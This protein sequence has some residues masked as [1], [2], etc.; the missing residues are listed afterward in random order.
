MCGLRTPR[1]RFALHEGR[2]EHEGTKQDR[3]I[4]S[5]EVDASLC[6]EKVEW[7]LTERFSAAERSDPTKPATGG[8]ARNDFMLL[9]G[10]P[11]DSPLRQIR[12]ANPYDVLL[13]VFVFFVP[14]VKSAARFPLKNPPRS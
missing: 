7:V 13:R 14:F 12:I 1:Q 5:R 6:A 2:E 3:Q 10:G 8:D 9:L 11:Q 4:L